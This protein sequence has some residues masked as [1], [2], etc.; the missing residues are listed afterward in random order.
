[1][2]S[3]GQSEDD[4]S[5]IREGGR[6]EPIDGG[7]SAASSEDRLSPLRADG[8]LPARGH[9]GMA[10]DDEAR[11][12]MAEDAR[13]QKSLV[14][15]CE[16]CGVRGVYIEVREVW[17]DGQYFGTF[18]GKCEMDRGRRRSRSRSEAESGPIP[19]RPGVRRL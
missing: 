6:G 9:R 12:D 10:Q 16:I 8:L 11:G 7:A 14:R 15:R 2:E 18:C 1:M 17:I 19:K 13:P 3:H 5:R 4:R